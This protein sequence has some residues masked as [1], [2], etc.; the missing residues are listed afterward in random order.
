G[1]A[2]A[3]TVL[4]GLALPRLVFDFDPLKLKDPKTES[5]ATLLDLMQDPWATPNTLNV[6][7]PSMAAAHAM[8][9]ALARLPEVRKA[10]TILDFVP[11]DQAAKLAILDDLDLILG[12]TLTPAAVK[13]APTD[14]EIADAAANAQA[15]AK[16]YLDSKSAVEPLRTAALR[17]TASIDRVLAE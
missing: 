11:T 2:A 3:A 4:A 13:S 10:R 9:E 12:P 8:A 5:M 16:R 7:T 1:M 15:S 17:F 6:L 14:A